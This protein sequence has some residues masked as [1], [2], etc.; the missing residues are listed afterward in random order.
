MTHEEAKNNGYKCP[1]CQTRLN[2]VREEY[3]CPKC[4]A[5]AILD[6]ENFISELDTVIEFEGGEDARINHEI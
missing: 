3:S 4:L 1:K 5:A 2:E 6:L